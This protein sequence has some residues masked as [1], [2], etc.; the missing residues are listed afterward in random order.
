MLFANT[1]PCVP[2]ADRSPLK[3][4]ARRRPLSARM[5]RKGPGSPLDGDRRY[6]S[7]RGPGLRRGF[8]GEHRR[9]GAACW[10][11]RS[12]SNVCRRWECRFIGPQTRVGEVSEKVVAKLDHELGEVG[13]DRCTRRGA[14]RRTNDPPTGVDVVLRGGCRMYERHVARFK[15]EADAFERSRRHLSAKQ[16]RATTTIPTNTPDT[17]RSENVAARRARIRPEPD[18]RNHNGRLAREHPCETPVAVLPSP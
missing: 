6:G 12:E 2:R 4:S 17:T 9:G 1:V 16:N 13:R 10:D 18:H 3:A 8:G 7:E 5:P 14:R 11:R 15:H